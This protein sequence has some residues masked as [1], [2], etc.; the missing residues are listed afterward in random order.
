M[1]GSGDHHGYVRSV[2]TCPDCGKQCYLTRAD[3][4]RAAKTIAPN[5]H[6]SPYKCGEF[7]HFGKL[8]TVVARGYGTRDAS[9]EYPPSV[10]RDIDPVAALR[11]VRERSVPKPPNPGNI[12]RRDT[13]DNFGEIV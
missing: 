6:F 10:T 13:G 12:G 8:A 9:R 4:K 5:A 2:F 11:A 7:Y 3:A 1:M